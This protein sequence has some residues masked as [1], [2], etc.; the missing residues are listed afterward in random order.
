MNKEKGLLATVTG[1]LIAV[2]QVIGPV[3]AA[4]SRSDSE[5]LAAIEEVT[6]TAQK[7]EEN[8]Q[9]VPIS[10]KVYGAEALKLGAVNTMTDLPSVAPALNFED[11]GMGAYLNFSMRGIGAFA[12][13]SG[14]QP[15]VGLV[16][17]GV[18]I[19]RPVEFNIG[20]ADIESIQLINGPQGTLFGANNIGGLIYVTTGR[21]TETFEGSVEAILTT[22]D[23]K[24]TRAMV[25]GPLTDRIRG[26]VSA[27][28]QDRD[29]F[30]KNIYPGSDRAG[31]EE[32]QG[33]TAKLEIDFNDS[34]SLLLSAD[35]RDWQSTNR[36]VHVDATVPPAIPGILE[37]L[38][39]G[40]PV[41]GQRIIDD[42]ELINANWSDVTDIKNKGFSAELVWHM[43][44]VFTFRSI[45]SY[46]DLDH[47]GTLDVA[48]SP[49]TL[50]DPRGMNILSGERVNRGIDPAQDGEMNYQRLST[51]VEYFTQELR[52]N[53]ATS[54]FDGNVGLYYSDTDEAVDWNFPLLIGSEFVA[55]DI[56]DIE[57]GARS[58]AVFGDVTWNV[59]DAVSVFAG[60]RWA[61]EKVTNNY[62][63]RS[64]F[65]D[66]T[67][68][69]ISGSNDVIFNPNVVPP[70]DSFNVSRK[71]SGLWSGRAGVRWNVTDDQNLYASVSRGYTGAAADSSTTA[72]AETAFIDPTTAISFEIG[73][74]SHW[75]DSRVRLN[76]ALFKT[77]LEDIQ[78]NFYDSATNQQIT[79][80]AGEFESQGLELQLTALLTDQLTL[81]GD[82]SLLDT[83]H[84]EREIFQPCYFGQTTAEGCIETGP[85]QFAQDIYGRSGVNAPEVK[86]NV[87]AHYDLFTRSMPF[88]ASA[89]VSY[90]WT[91]DVSFQL[92]YDP[93][94]SYQRSYGTLDITLAISD[95]QGRYTVSLFG[96]NVLDENFATYK[97]S[98]AGRN[99]AGRGTF[100]RGSFAYWGLRASYN[101]D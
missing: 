101:F 17:D 6:V 53:F 49:G 97:Y 58:L 72:T 99:V 40:D 68:Y 67:Q 42:P 51:A 10:I 75:L 41:L 52:L 35:Y 8:I 28:M 89:T 86:Y 37:I 45:S 55:N 63:I 90:T 82:V 1:A 60:Y 80:N 18:S 96:K 70:V 69:T 36:S 73:A 54:R 16:V 9:D 24:I 85:G 92:L 57:L 12:P 88:D 79:F 61:E 66:S 74:K 59:T 83:E 47:N 5:R 94:A 76:A 30:L 77:T 33:G 32:A 87:N 95:K 38:G 39:N 48:E 91:D 62:R 93:D 4:E 11:R 23:E 98:D 15:S 84:T 34:T 81:S 14:V 3:N 25:S 43:S 29:G 21:P 78:A 19:N 64:F 100:G 22:D 31:G 13:G 2:T 27:Y 56:Q 46:R 50:A 20:L 71:D 44:D 65:A 7:R 26:R